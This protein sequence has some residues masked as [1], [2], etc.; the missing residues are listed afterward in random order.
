MWI[1]TACVDQHQLCGSALPVW[2]STSYSPAVE[3]PSE[4]PSQPT[5]TA[6]QDQPCM[7]GGSESWR[8]P[9][10]SNSREG[11]VA[12]KVFCIYFWNLGVAGGSLVA[13]D[14]DSKQWQR[15]RVQSSLRKQGR[16]GEGCQTL[17]GLRRL[18]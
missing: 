13:A 8:E 16:R 18:T 9:K 11:S 17:K 12:L 10:F 5:S 6:G 4:L 3:V 15:L 7:Q 1:S 14:V 2:I